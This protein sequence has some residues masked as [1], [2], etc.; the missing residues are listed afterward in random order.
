MNEITNEK[1]FSAEKASILESSIRKLFQ[2]PKRILGPYIQEGMTVLDFGCGPGFF[3]VEL[4]KMVGAS[5]K[6]IA[7]DLQVEML[8]KLENKIKN[9]EL[10]KRIELHQTEGDKIGVV[11]K[12]D[13]AFVFYA[14]HEV[15]DQKCF[16]KEIKTLLK[17]DGKVFIVEPKFKVSKSEF[18]KSITLAEAAG[19]KPETETKIFLS[20]TVLLR[21]SAGCSKNH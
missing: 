12:V 8:K 16:F 3:S 9:T 7:A 13:F 15:P 11:E 2:N 20:R 4:A 1:V 14:L 19:L 17:P 6:V 18:Q 10:E 21:I 5:G